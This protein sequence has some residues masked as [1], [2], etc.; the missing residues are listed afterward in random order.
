MSLKNINGT[1]LLD[2]HVFALAHHCV[3]RTCDGL[4]LE[5]REK[6]KEK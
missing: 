6:R 3:W 1:T 4:S 2:T 5:R